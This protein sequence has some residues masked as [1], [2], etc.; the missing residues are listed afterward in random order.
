MP[1]KKQ[2]APLPQNTTKFSKLKAKESITPTHPKGKKGNAMLRILGGVVVGLGGLIFFI[3]PL[4]QCDMSKAKAS[5][6]RNTVGAIIRGQEAH[7][8]ETNQFAES[9]QELELGIQE[10]TVNYHYTVVKQTNSVINYAIP[11]APKKGWFGQSSKP[12]MPSIVGGVFLVPSEEDPQKNV[13]KNIM[14]QQ[15]SMDS[16]LPMEPTLMN[17]TPTCPP[18][19]IDLGS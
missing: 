16:S 2:P 15:K 7:L 13:I 9:L 19:Y 14:C 4:A 1:L 11:I 17:T 10:T 3:I 12:M 18:E 8:L 5:E 6:A